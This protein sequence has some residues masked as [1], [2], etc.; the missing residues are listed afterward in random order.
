MQFRHHHR[1]SVIIG[2]VGECHVPGGGV[3]FRH[4]AAAFDHAAAALLLARK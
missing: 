3:V 2:T 1:A 4:A